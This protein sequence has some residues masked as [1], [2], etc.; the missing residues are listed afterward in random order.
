M[1]LK[2]KRAFLALLVLALGTRAVSFGAALS[3]AQQTTQQT[4]ERR[5]HP[6]P[7]TTTL[8]PVTFREVQ[9]Q[10]LIVRI[11]INSVGPFNFAI[12]TGAGAMLLSPQVAAEAKA[13]VKAGRRSSIAGLSGINTSAQEASIK[14]L[15][16]GE[17]DNSLPAK[18]TVLITNGLP[19]GVDGVL[20]PTEAFAPFGF[21]IDIP[22]HEFSVFD[23]R[24]APLRVDDQPTDGAVVSWLREAHSQ[25]PFVQL[26]NG[27]RALLDT[28]SNFGLA[29]KA[30]DSARAQTDEYSVRD[31]GG[32]RVSARRARPTTIAIGALTLRNIPTDVI[33][34]AEADAPVLL[35]LNALRPFRLRFDPV[36]HL[37]EIVPGASERR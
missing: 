11:W 1:K 26:D 16:I 23:P 4:R 14:T 37:I 3:V 20:D 27:D 25:R 9:G 8:L 18:G 7:T 29:I 33:S 35:G 17:S 6:A 22:R 19:R 12:D 13:T 36:H 34:G 15:A 24:T 2:L 5:S 21:V 30:R 28:G 32:G 10:G 31:V